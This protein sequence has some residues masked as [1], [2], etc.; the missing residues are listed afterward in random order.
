MS[1]REIVIT[2]SSLHYL[3]E[4]SGH[5]ASTARKVGF[6]LHP[7]AET[8]GRPRGPVCILPGRPAL[9]AGVCYTSS[10]LP[11]ICHI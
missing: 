2:F 5:P 9:G 8:E 11:F 1:R 7:V 4:K 3:E 6:L 10:E